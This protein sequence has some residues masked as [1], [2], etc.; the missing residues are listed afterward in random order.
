MTMLCGLQ[1]PRMVSERFVGMNYTQNNPES[2][3]D[4]VLHQYW[5]HFAFT[6][7][8][9]IHLVIAENVDIRLIVPENSTNL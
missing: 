4:G 3:T 2:D 1:A 7:G 8:P 5:S 6:A 9:P